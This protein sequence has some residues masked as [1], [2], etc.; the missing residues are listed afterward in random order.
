MESKYIKSLVEQKFKI[1]LSEFKRDRELVY[2][3]RVYYALADV[4]CRE[5]SGTQIANTIGQDHATRLHSIKEWDKIHDQ[6]YFEVFKE[7]FNEIKEFIESHHLNKEPEKA[8]KTPKEIENE[9]RGKMIRLIEQN[10]KVIST[11][12]HKS[13]LFSKDK[14]FQEIFDLPESDLQ[15]F[16]QL[17]KIFLKRKHHEGKFSTNEVA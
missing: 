1:N 7:A 8:L 4:F 3:R 14:I 12:K 17:A 15:E 5:E 11:L 6:K 16:K 2:K 13:E 9:Y 10:H